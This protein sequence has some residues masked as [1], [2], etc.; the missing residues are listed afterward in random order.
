MDKNYDKQK[1]LEILVNS[2]VSIIL[3]ELEDGSKDSS[4]FV[5]KL[6]LSDTEIKERLAYVIQHGF[7][8]TSL[9]QNKPILP[10]DLINHP[11]IGQSSGRTWNHVMTIGNFSIKRR[12]VAQIVCAAGGQGDGPSP[13]R[14]D[15]INHPITVVKNNI[16][17]VGRPMGAHRVD[18]VPR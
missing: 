12:P 9:D 11:E 8:R 18:G 1:M 5:E 3:S 15:E 10:S 17:A 13:I 6:H 16:L 2:D 7:V 4:Y 14:L